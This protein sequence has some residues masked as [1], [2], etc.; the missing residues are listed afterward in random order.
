MNVGAEN[1]GFERHLRTTAITAVNQGELARHS[2]GTG[3]QQVAEL[4][5]HICVA[6]DNGGG[7]AADGVSDGDDGR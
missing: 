7:A 4:V 5:G 1:H 3:G 6:D 2:L